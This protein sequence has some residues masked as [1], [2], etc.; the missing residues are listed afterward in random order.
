MITLVALLITTVQA[1]S[2]SNAR[3]SAIRATYVQSGADEYITTLVKHIDSKYVPEYIRDNGA[4]AAIL[5]QCVIRNEISW[6]WSF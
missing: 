5:L 1:S 4:V 2:T 3:E 6:K